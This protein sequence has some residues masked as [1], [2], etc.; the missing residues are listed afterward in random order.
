[1]E[2]LHFELFKAKCII[3]VSIWTKKCSKNYTPHFVSLYIY[4]YL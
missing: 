3:R 4:I 2:N 1:M